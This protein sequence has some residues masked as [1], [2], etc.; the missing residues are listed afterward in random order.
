MTFLWCLD[1]FHIYLADEG[2]VRALLNK[3]VV[4]TIEIHYALSLVLHPVWLSHSSKQ[5]SG[6]LDKVIFWILIYSVE[7]DY[8]PRDQKVYRGVADELEQRQNRFGEWALKYTGDVPINRQLSRFLGILMRATI[9]ISGTLLLLWRCNGWV[10][11]L[12]GGV[13][14]PGLIA[15][16]WP[17]PTP[18]RSL[19]SL[20]R[21]SCNNNQE[22]VSNFLSEV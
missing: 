2:K 10:R 11:Y 3:K 12:G 1:V 15:E 9:V 7:L 18:T 20:S 22:H 8:G 21:S 6:V 19:L 17:S 14:D 4:S 5:F 13:M 16:L